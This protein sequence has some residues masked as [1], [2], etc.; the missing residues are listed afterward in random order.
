MHI[1]EE[2]SMYYGKKDILNDIVILLG[3]RV[4]EELTM[5]DISTGASSDLKRATSLAHEMVAKYGMSEKIGPICY[6]S[7]EEVFLGRDYGHSKQYSEM[8]AAQIDKEVET[9]LNSQYERA[10]KLLSENMNKLKNV[11][12]ALLSNEVLDEAEFLKYY[13]KGD[14]EN[15]TSN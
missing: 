12:E 6:D 15:E 1:P 3:G 7:N 4:A 14:F 13:N 11:A 2:D 5:D 10:K 9:L 8:I